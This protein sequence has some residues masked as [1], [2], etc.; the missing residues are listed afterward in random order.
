[1]PSSRCI[2]TT[3]EMNFTTT[4]DKHMLSLADQKPTGTAVHQGTN[5]SGIFYAVSLLPLTEDLCI[6]FV[7]M[8]LF[9]FLFLYMYI[10]YLDIYP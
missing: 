6:K 7:S 4:A 8:I 10:L 5:N 2:V 3:C 9:S 1:M